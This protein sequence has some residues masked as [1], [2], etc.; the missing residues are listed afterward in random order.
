MKHF[1]VDPATLEEWD[2][3]QPTHGI[4]DDVLAMAGDS[5]RLQMILNGSRTCEIC[6]VRK[7]GKGAFIPASDFQKKVD[8]DRRAF[9][10]DLCVRAN[11]EIGYI[12]FWVFA[13][14]NANK[15]NTWYALWFDHEGDEHF[16]FDDDRGWNRQRTNGIDSYLSVMEQAMKEGFE[17][18]R[19]AELSERQK[20]A[21]A[22]GET[23]GNA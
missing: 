14:D 10:R 5:I 2:A 16:Y 9:I 22:L 18:L 13:W 20:Y 6:I 3:G 23:K 8:T 7:D 15:P 4:D 19:D 21:A 12:G 17:R 1:V 11:R